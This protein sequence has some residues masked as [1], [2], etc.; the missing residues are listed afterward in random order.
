MGGT[1]RPQTRPRMSFTPVVL[2]FASVCLG[3][4]FPLASVNAP[5]EDSQCRIG[6]LVQD[7]ELPAAL[8]VAGDGLA[9]HPGDLEARGWRA[10]LLAC[11]QRWSE[12]ELEYLAVLQSAPH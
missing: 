6:E 11:T 9:A 10:G 3:T 2:A 12:S 7:Q 1:L 8:A 4:R 5:S